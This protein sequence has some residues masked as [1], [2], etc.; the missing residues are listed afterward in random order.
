MLY[1]NQIIIL[2][3]TRL[4]ILTLINKKLKT[5]HMQVP[6]INLSLMLFLL[7]IRKEV[8]ALARALVRIDPK[9]N[10]AHQEQ[11]KCNNSCIK[12]PKRQLLSQE[13][14]Q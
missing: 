1:N 6:R 4:E 9:L 8:Q 5:P 7:L 12:S 13:N 3:R 14:I 2:T 11:L 10:L